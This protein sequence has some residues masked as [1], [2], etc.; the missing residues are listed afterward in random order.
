VSAVLQ[1]VAH[2]H[3]ITSTNRTANRFAQTPIPFFL[4]HVSADWQTQHQRR[5]TTSP[6][7]AGT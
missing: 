3:A 1:C 6:C 4:T 7:T 5:R 2:A